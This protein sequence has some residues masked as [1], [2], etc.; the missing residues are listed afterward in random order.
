MSNP[1]ESPQSTMESAGPPVRK[2]GNRLRRLL[3]HA[4]FYSLFLVLFNLKRFL[5]PPEVLE[6]ARQSSF[7][8]SAAALLF[9]YLMAWMFYSGTRRRR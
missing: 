9:F 8:S 7:L 6:N 2:K 3:K 4:A 5:A 1:Y